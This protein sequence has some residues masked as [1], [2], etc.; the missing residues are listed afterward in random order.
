MIARFPGTCG[1]GCGRRFA[2]GEQLVRGA[3]GGWARAACG[4]AP[5]RPAAAPAGDGLHASTA[6]ILDILARAKAVA[7]RV[8]RETAA[9]LGRRAG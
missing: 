3:G 8:E 2:A 9:R 1:C 6:E 5:A 7:E 4:A